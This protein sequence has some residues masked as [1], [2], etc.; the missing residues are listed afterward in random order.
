[1]F[2]IGYFKVFVEFF[3]FIYGAEDFEMLKLDINDMFM[4]LVEKYVKIE[5]ILDLLR[6]VFIDLELVIRVSNWDR[7]F[8][9][10]L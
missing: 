10:R 7:L 5:V 1:M 4:L 2:A 3:E 9:V 8:N 6:V